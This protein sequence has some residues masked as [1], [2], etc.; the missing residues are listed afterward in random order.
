MGKAGT[1]KDTIASYIKNIIENEEKQFVCKFAFADPIKH[2]A[3]NMFPN[4]TTKQLWGSSKF[5]DEI[6]KGAFAV[7][8]WSEKNYRGRLT[9]RKLLQNIGTIG[10]TY[11]PKCWIK[12]LDYRIKLRLHGSSV[13]ITDAR[14]K[15][16]Y[17]YLKRNNYF[18]INVVR[19]T[20]K[21]KQTE[22]HITEFGQDK[23][24]DFDYVI[25][26]NI[27]LPKLKKLIENKVMPEIQKHQH[28]KKKAQ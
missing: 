4:I 15:N 3:A 28:K 7:H 8:Q 10:R 24:T 1:G 19:K 25:D 21:N 16:E 14:Q 2:I 22:S 26:N 23:I 17:D 5:R 9:V 6:V 13:I 20:K 27:S 18:I 12:C 11:D